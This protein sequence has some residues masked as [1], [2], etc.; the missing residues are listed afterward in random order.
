MSESHDAF[1][2]DVAAYAI[3]ALEPNDASRVRSH[4]QSCAQC[5]EELQALAPT[6]TAIGIS[7]EACTNASSGAIAPPSSLLKARI[8]REVRAN[9]GAR[10]PESSSV[11]LWP[12]YLVAAAAL[13][14][15]LLSSL[16]NISL[17]ARLHQAQSDVEVATARSYALASDLTEA[18]TMI[19]DLASAQ[20][21]H[22]PLNGGDVVRVADRLYLTMQRMPVAPRGKVYQAWT[23]GKGST[24]MAPS[25]TFVPDAHG[26]A[27]IHLPVNGAATSV[28]AVTVEP[29]GGSK[30]PTSAPIALA[31]LN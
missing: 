4:L 21:K 6:V 28:V 1:L 26:V 17:T 5:R 8:M 3:G 27:V 11:R 12:A 15:A 22:Y 7:A 14:L 13:A 20:A 9:P 30:T 19:S 31:T 10:R 29:E 2:D 24:T 25:L 18:R 23:R 16:S